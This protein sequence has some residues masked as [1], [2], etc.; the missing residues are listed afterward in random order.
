[1]LLLSLPELCLDQE[2]SQG[3]EVVTLSSPLAPTPLLQ[4]RRPFRAASEEPWHLSHLPSSYPPTHS[5]PNNIKFSR[6]LLSVTL[7][8]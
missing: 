8:Q 2:V 7:D 5:L 6:L 3:P 1:M 4:A